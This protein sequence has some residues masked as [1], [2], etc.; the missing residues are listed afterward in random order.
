MLE[1]VARVLDRTLE[2]FPAA[3]QVAAE[4][5]LESVKVVGAV[6]LA[7]GAVLLV[8]ALA[9]LPTAALVL[10]VIWLAQQVGLL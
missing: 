1:K 8:A 2:R 10:G 4:T 6:M 3:M 7:L 5:V 9:L